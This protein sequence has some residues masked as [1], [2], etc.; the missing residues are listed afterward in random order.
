MAASQHEQTAFQEA[1]AA[2]QDTLGNSD[3]PPI[4][5]KKAIDAFIKIQFEDK[6][7]AANRLY[8][9]Y[10]E[11]PTLE[12]KEAADTALQELKNNQSEFHNVVE[13]LKKGVEVEVSDESKNSMFAPSAEINQYLQDYQKQVLSIVQSAKKT[14]ETRIH[15]PANFKD[16]N[17]YFHF[18]IQIKD[19]YRDLE[20]L[21]K[22]YIEK[23]KD[24]TSTNEEIQEAFN[25]YARLNLEIT[26]S[27]SNIKEYLPVELE[28]WDI[29]VWGQIWVRLIAYL[30]GVQIIN[31]AYLQEQEQKITTQFK[32][33]IYSEISNIATKQFES[34]SFE[35][36]GILTQLKNPSNIKDLTSTIEKLQNKVKPKLL[37]LAN[38]IDLESSKNFKELKRL[39]GDLSTFM[40]GSS[41]G[42]TRSETLQKFFKEI[43]DATTLKNLSNISSQFKEAGTFSSDTLT[44]LQKLVNK[45]LDQSA[46]FLALQSLLI[47]LQTE[48]PVSANDIFNKMAIRRPS[49]LITQEIVIDVFIQNILKDL[50]ATEEEQINHLFD[51]LSEYLV[52]LET[53][54]SDSIK[55]LI[56]KFNEARQLNI[57]NKVRSAIIEG[58]NRVESTLEENKISISL[59]QIRKKLELAPNT[60]Q[61]R[62]TPIDP[63]ANSMFNILRLHMAGAKKPNYQEDVTKIQEPHN[64]H[65]RPSTKELQP[66]YDR[67]LHSLYSFTNAICGSSIIEPQQEGESLRHTSRR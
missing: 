13:G 27:M 59:P 6:V 44:K 29:F 50:P 12:N 52:N 3:K 1:L 64:R 23:I 54:N 51:K 39:A 4:E 40:G 5:K 61:K 36:K 10:I 11:N 60:H 15:M 14:R 66:E 48:I 26:A 57:T 33:D 18:F 41:Y 42:F 8:Q 35:D 22:V 24:G 20:Q 37:M 63:L 58:L 21:R 43:S 16:V 62:K 31:Q 56:E 19:L 67:Y 65:S 2:L 17:E 9:L 30:W 32:D 47:N 55:N 28:F 25:N 7:K 34:A 53:L 49:G 38:H 45:N 46:N